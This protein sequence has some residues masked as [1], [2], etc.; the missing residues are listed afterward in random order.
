M[1]SSSQNFITFENLIKLESIMKIEITDPNENPENQIST[2]PPSFPPM[3]IMNGF[4]QSA[5]SNRFE[6]IEGVQPYQN[7]P[8]QFHSSFHPLF[9]GYP[10]HEMV[11]NNLTL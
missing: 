9:A 10:N 8:L 11:R 3:A 5:L 7:V 6:P 2:P 1:G 4:N